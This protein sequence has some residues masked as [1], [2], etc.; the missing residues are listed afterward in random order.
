LRRVEDRAISCHFGKFV[1]NAVLESCSVELEYK[2]VITPAAH[3]L[4][5]LLFHLYELIR[6]RLHFST[7]QP[8][9]FSVPFK[10]LTQY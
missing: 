10:V 7:I 1:W 3:L 2:I 5:P 9:C 4:T 6:P 8:C